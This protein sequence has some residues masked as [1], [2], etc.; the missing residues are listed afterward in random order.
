MMAIEYSNGKCPQVD[1]CSTDLQQCL[2]QVGTGNDKAD[3]AEGSSATC[4]RMSD[5]CVQKAA[6]QCPPQ[7]MTGLCPFPAGLIMLVLGGVF[8]AGYIRKQ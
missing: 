3:C 4:Y 8:L 7:N 5:T 1:A 2:A 6:G